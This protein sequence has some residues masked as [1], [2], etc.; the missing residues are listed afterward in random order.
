MNKNQN[1][2]RVLSLLFAMVMLVS[3]M[4]VGSVV[5]SAEEAEPVQ[6]DH[7]VVELKIGGVTTSYTSFDAAW[8]AMNATGN[9]QVDFY[10]LENITLTKSYVLEKEKHINYLMSNPASKF[11]LTGT[12]DEPL[13]VIN[14]GRMTVKNI[15]IVSKGDTFQV[16]GGTLSIQAVGGTSTQRTNVTSLEGSVLNMTGGSVDFTGGPVLTA[17]GNQPAVKNDGK[18]TLT[19]KQWSWNNESILQAPNSDTVVDWAGE[20]SLNISYGF[21][22]GEIAADDAS[23]VNISGGTFTADMTKY[24]DPSYCTV[25]DADGKYVLAPKVVTVDGVAYADWAEACANITGTSEIKLYTDVVNNGS[26]SKGAQFKTFVLDLNGH[27]F[28]TT[29]IGVDGH[30]T[31]KIIDSVGTGSVKVT[32]YTALYANG[33]LDVASNVDF[34]SKIQFNYHSAGSTGCFLVDGVKMIGRGH[35]QQVDGTMGTT[36]GYTVLVN[37]LKN[38]E[39]QS[40]NFVLNLDFNTAAIEKFVIKANLTIAADATLALDANTS[41]T[42][43]GK[44]D[45]EGTVAVSTFEQFKVIV[46]KANVKNVR[47]DASFAIEGITLDKAD[48]NYIGAAKLLNTGVAITAGTFDAD[49]KSLCPEGYCVPEENGVWTVYSAHNYTSAET[50]PTTKD[51][52]FTTYTCTRCAHEYVVVAEG[53]RLP[54]EFKGVRLLLK[55]GIG[56]YF[57]VNANDLRA[58]ENYV[59]VITYA[60]TEYEVSFANWKDFGDGVNLGILF[61]GVDA[62]SIGN[63]VSIVITVD[64]A[65]VSVTRTTSVKAYAQAIIGGD[66]Y[67]AEAK[68]LANALLNY[69]ALAENA[70]LGT[71]KDVIADVNA[72][73]NSKFEKLD[74]MSADSVTTEDYYGSSVNLNNYLGFNFKFFANAVKG[75][76]HAVITYNGKTVKVDASVFTTETKN[77]N[78]LVVIELEQLLASDAAFELTCTVYNGET[79]LATATDS[80]YNYCARALAGLAKMDGTAY[81]AQKYKSEFYKALVL[82]VEAAKGY[83]EAIAE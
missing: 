52:G 65:E 5:A 30:K 35:F 15:N 21:I 25:K 44:L 42:I 73:V 4:V 69:G 31:F 12:T 55:D 54:L 82:Y 53:T 16:G 75:A 29:T 71:N 45:G 78:K 62:K 60:G 83:T 74:D 67:T 36:G 17:L 26:F 61:D 20:G 51:D 3:M 56:I 22:D 64:G 47:L 57:M 27:N 24:C 68:E 14:K 41:L 34:N 7:Y 1:W 49:V 37:G 8:E 77:G 19:I 11:T 46:E 70:I 32:N 72:D 40:G 63:E 33:Y 2:R 23:K 50:A 59:A 81:E 10:I 9:V 48:V 66:K 79:E 28:T 38:F 6:E 13:F 18:G 76:T 58:D 39:L 80:V 43:A